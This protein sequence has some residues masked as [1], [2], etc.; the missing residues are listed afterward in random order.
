MSVSYSNVL[1]N[2]N[3]ITAD[4]PRNNRGMNVQDY[5]I[6]GN[7]EECWIFYDLDESKI[8]QSNCLFLTNSKGAEIV[9]TPKKKM[10]KT[11]KE[12]DNFVE[13]NIPT[14]KEIPQTTNSSRNENVGLNGVYECLTMVVT[15]KESG[16]A[17][18]RAMGVTYRGTWLD[19]EDEAII[20]VDTETNQFPQAI[21]R[22]IG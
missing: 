3:G 12:F 7:G 13:E 2:D 4:A 21:T 10:C 16:T 18:I 5:K 15:L 9:C 22:I 11:K 19:D 8:S 6:R 20:Y 14:K 17:K 1:G